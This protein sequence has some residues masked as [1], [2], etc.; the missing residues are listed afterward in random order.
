MTAAPV[1]DLPLTLGHGD[2]AASW[3]AVASGVREALT[4]LG[5]PPRDAVLLVPFAQLVPLARQALAAQGGWQP[6]VETTR[7][8]AASLGPPPQPQAG[9]PT[10]DAATDRLAA[11]AL[12]RGQAWAQA[13]ARRDAR[14]FE[15]GVAAVVEAAHFWLRQAAAVAP[16]DRAAWWENVR[17]ALPATAGTGSLEASLARVAVEWVAHASAPATDRLF[18]LRPSA[19][20]T[21]VL[22]GVDPV[23]QAVLAQAE[24]PAA[25]L[26]ADAAQEDAA[27]GHA[28]ASLAEP[29]RPPTVRLAADA[30]EEAE[31]AAHEVLAALAAGRAPVA[32]IAEDRELVRRVRALLERRQVPLHDETGWTL[33]TTRAAA[34]VMALLRA[35]APAAGPDEWLDWLKCEDHGE[36]VPQLE[37]RWRREHHA[38]VEAPPEQRDG[39]RAE[40]QARTDAFWQAQRERLAPLGGPRRRPL[41]DW[42]G[43]LRDVLAAGPEAA[44]WETDAA[45]RQVAQALRWHDAQAGHAAW[46]AAASQALTLSDLTVWIDAVLEQVSFVPPAPAGEAA[47]VVTPLARALLRPF[48]QVVL[49]G[50]DERRLGAA[51]A[52]P[53]LVGEALLRQLGLEDRLARQRRGLLAFTHL[54]RAPAVVL[55]RRRA[56]GHELLAPSPWLDLMALARRQARRA[57]LVE[58][59]VALATR[60]VPAAPVAP[61]RAIAAP[62]L[63]ARVS[64]SAVSALRDCPY[65]FFVQAVLRLRASDELEDDPDKSDYG[66]WLH[67]VLQRFHDERRASGAEG[68][69]IDVDAATE[70]LLALADAQAQAMNLSPAALL[71]YQAALPAFAARYLDWLAGHEQQGWR[72]REGEVARERALTGP[73]APRLYGVIDRIDAAAAGVAG[74]MLLDYKTGSA[75]SLKARVR[76]PT[77]DTQLAFYAALSEVEGL[78]LQAAYVA[79]DER[80]RIEVIAHDQV[81]RSAHLLVEHLGDEWQRLREGTPLRALGEGAV[82]DYCDA[83]GLCRRDHWSGTP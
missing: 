15:H 5:S 7:T 64:A 29:E 46:R 60:E 55:L 50:A 72:Y 73:G 69:A 14:A 9:E 28:P 49:P 16:G 22:G 32:L 47:V 77:E 13:W 83:R 37:A 34:S 4:R 76:E 8:L 66:N 45:A 75:S 36:W 74:L 30:D 35:A 3:R 31:G 63:P 79:L 10:G 82:C 24:V 2:I 19:W 23:A 58:T 68:T 52:T 70:R 20:L 61:P 17:Q 67:A 12:L 57:P 41:A 65:R 78:P 25:R 62:A 80:E 71:P 11:A 42:L 18:A 43:A 56:D 26:L 53:A 51:S 1:I 33:A 38:E 6:R 40:R 48:A 54:L 44:Q 21:L 81:Q 59:P 39:A 27:A